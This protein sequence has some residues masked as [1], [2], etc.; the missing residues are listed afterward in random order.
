M[1]G[2]PPVAKEFTLQRS[3][4]AG[5]SLKQLSIVGV[6]NRELVYEARINM[7]AKLSVTAS[8]PTTDF[9]TGILQITIFDRDMK[10]LAERVCFVNNS[11]YEFDADAWISELNVD[12][13]SLNRAE[14]KISDDLP[15]NLSLSI[16]DADL[17]APPENDD[18]IVTRTLLT[19]DLR[20][21]IYQPY[22]YFFSTSDSVPLQLDLVMLT[23][24]LRR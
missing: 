11:G 15:V 8:I 5:E 21:N 17:N 14:V 16:T 3:E 2:T 22:Y 9:P 4:N 24:G 20:G 7:T 19:G 1:P 6:M 13:R 12:K 18:N 23:N 10:P